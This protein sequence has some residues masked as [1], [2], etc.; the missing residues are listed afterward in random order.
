MA[1]NAGN[2][3]PGIGIRFHNMPRTGLIYWLN[4]IG[5]VVFCRL[6]RGMALDTFVLFLSKYPAISNKGI[7]DLDSLQ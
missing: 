6:D 5:H 7:R 2:R 3:L 4:K 1:Y